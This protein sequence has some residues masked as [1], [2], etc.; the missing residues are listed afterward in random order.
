MSHL[1]NNASTFPLTHA[2]FVNSFHL[3]HKRS[4]L[5][6]NVNNKSITLMHTI[7]INKNNQ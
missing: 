2:E 7:S 4:L 5:P 1:Q 6:V 3:L